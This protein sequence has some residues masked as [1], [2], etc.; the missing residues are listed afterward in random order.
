MTT[1]I[2]QGLDGGFFE[3]LRRYFKSL[4]TSFSNGNGDILSPG[5]PVFRIFP[6]FTTSFLNK[7]GDI[8]KGFAA[9]IRF[10]GPEFFGV[11]EQNRTDFGDDG[12]LGFWGRCLWVSHSGALKKIG[13][14]LG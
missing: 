12:L 5:R 8:S 14:I 1:A 13:R 4:T 2:F 6:F 11:L 3:W 9:A 10:L 7:N